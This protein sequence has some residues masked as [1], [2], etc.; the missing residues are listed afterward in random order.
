MSA[1]A[2][3]PTPFTPLLR[4]I[5][6]DVPGALGAIFADGEGEVVDA[7]SRDAPEYPLLVL[8]AHYGVVLNPRKSSTVRFAPGDRMIV[9][10]ER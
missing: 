9:L 8:G 4:R 10:A 2:R 5:V 1:S 6:D 7:V 3:A